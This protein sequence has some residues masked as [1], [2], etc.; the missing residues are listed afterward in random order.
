[1]L[2]GKQKALYFCLTHT[3]ICI[4]FSSAKNIIGINPPLSL[5]A[6][7]PPTAAAAADYYFAGKYGENR[8]SNTVWFGVRA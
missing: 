2:F 5:L 4:L 1:V 8:N 6:H 7:S 3:Y